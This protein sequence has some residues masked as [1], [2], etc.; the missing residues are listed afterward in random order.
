M[1]PFLEEGTKLVHLFFLHTR[2]VFVTFF[3]ETEPIIE[4][5]IE[6]EIHIYF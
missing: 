4:I 6:M 3:S 5:K 1:F 2:T